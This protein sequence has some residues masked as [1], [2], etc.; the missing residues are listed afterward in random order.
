MIEHTKLNWQQ[1]RWH[2]DAEKL[3]FKTTKEVEP[4]DVIIGQDDA[5]EA[6]QFAIECEAYGQNVY[7]RGLSGTGRMS[8]VSKILR[9]VKPKLKQKTEHCYV[10]NFAQPDR[11]RL[12]SLPA[13]QGV[14]FKNM[15]DKLSLFISE[16]LKKAM[17]SDSLI[18]AKNKVEE[19]LQSKI[20]KITEP[21]ETELSEHSM[22]MLNVNSQQGQQTIIAPVMEEKVLDPNAWQQKVA[23]GEINEA[24][25]KALMDTQQ[26]FSKKLEEVGRKVNELKEQGVVAIRSLYEKHVS[27]LI[28]QEVASFAKQ[29]KVKAVLQFLESVKEDLLDQYFSP[30]KKAFNPYERYA[31]NVLL[32]HDDKKDCPVLV[33]RVP[34]LQNLLGSIES[35]WS[36][37]GPVLA[38]HMSIVGG[39]LLRA[40]G[41][42]LVL[43]ARDLLA[44]Q[45]AWK[46]LIRTIK[47]E[48]L[49]IV[50]AEM[51]WPFGQPSL[52][53]EP[54][55]VDIRVILLGDS[56]VYYHLD[57]QD[58]DFPEL[59]KV[60][61]D[62]DSV[63]SRDQEG[64]DNYAGI[65]AKIIKEDG[66]LPFDRFAIARLIEHGARVCS[67]DNK[68]T[69]KFS[70]VADLAREASYLA[71]K[72]KNKLV[73]GDDVV[74]AVRR[75]KK[76]AGL[77]SRKFQERLQDG[78]INL[79]TDG[80]TIGQ[81]NGLAVIHAGPIVY[82]FPSRITASIGPGR[83]GVIDIEGMAGKSGSIHTKGFHI[84]GGLLRYML[85]VEHPLTF[86]A[87]IAFEQSYGG[88]DGDSASGAE[89]CCL[90][91]ALTQVP[92]NQG[93]AMTG[94]IDQHGRLQAIGGV[95]E[96]IEGF[97]DTCHY[98]GLTGKQGVIIPRANAGELMLRTDVQ[99]ACKNNLFSIHAVSH[100]TEAIEVLME[101]SAGI[102]IDGF[103][104]ENSVMGKAMIMAKKYWQ[105]TQA[106]V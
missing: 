103:Y 40:D 41:G 104:A 49:E 16:D 59:F 3:G 66:L 34:S 46:T 65:I 85:P 78:T 26:V 84:L 82:G 94:A 28:D 8:M 27:K 88:I 89:F 42:F 53:P 102:L 19:N 56:S 60:L 80:F 105:N 100:I 32:Q 54:I 23:A 74:H 91:S 69:A 77:S 75:T 1:V 101:E 6:L 45:G 72:E 38:D 20:S 55:P 98:R 96:K 99:E 10:A 83:S 36:E 73:S 106:K 81:I 7:V 5:L 51:S 67:Q 2:C 12:I 30:K 50:P 58:P 35:K 62:F 14:K 95:N 13:G 90:M 76:R 64:F 63:I 93:F 9:D 39:S 21:F 52:K 17:E 11:P 33:E 61:A 97:F 43:D 57:N 31:V 79:D 87:S 18:Q 44:E 15:M 47:N 22:A 86:S 29:F 4:V 24:E 25:Q 48:L 92:I 71:N 70:R 37:N 68:L